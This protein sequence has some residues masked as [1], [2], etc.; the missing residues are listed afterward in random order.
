[1][2]QIEGRRIFHQAIKDGRQTNVKEFIR[3][4]PRLKKAYDSS[5]QSELMTALNAGQYEIYALLQSEGFRAGKY[6]EPSLVIEG[7]TIEEKDRLRQANLKYFGREDD[8]H[9]TYLLSKSR[10][11]IGQ[12][13]KKILALYWNNTNGWMPYRRFQPS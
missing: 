1:L 4:H 2:N 8:A 12:E 7:L 13:K 9:I 5:N 6:E 10:L 3:S 11:G